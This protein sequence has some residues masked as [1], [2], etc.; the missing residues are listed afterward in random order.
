M[1]EI[2]GMNCVFVIDLESIKNT[3]ELRT[4]QKEESYTNL[5]Y[6]QVVC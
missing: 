5:P 3:S 2:S 4:Y 1:T 6:L